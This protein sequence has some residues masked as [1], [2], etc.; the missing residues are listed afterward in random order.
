MCLLV[1]ML[2]FFPLDVSF[3][4]ALTKKKEELKRKGEVGW[5]CGVGDVMCLLLLYK[6]QRSVEK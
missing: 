4:F 3:R 1:S 5:W 6:T 2:L